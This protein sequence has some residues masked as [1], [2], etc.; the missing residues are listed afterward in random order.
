MAHYHQRSN[1]ESTFSMVKRKFGASVRAKTPAAQ[2]NE[3]LLKALSR[4]TNAAE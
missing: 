1:V 4:G 3:V 2:L